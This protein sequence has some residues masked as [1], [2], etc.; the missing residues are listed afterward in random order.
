MNFIAGKIEDYIG[1]LYGGLGL[2]IVAINDV[3]SLPK[4]FIKQ[5]E[6]INLEPE[7]QAPVSIQEKPVKA[8]KRINKLFY[9]WKKDRIVLFSREKNTPQVVLTRKET[10]LFDFL[11]TDRRTI[12][13]IAGQIWKVYKKA[14][15][16]KKVNNIRE[17][18][19]RINKR[20]EK[21]VPE[22]I[23]SELDNDSYYLTV[24]VEED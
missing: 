21:F 5:F 1:G 23:I 13:E 16:E 12:E 4:Y 22:D 3:A 7:K 2:L 8:V 20:C 18:R 10:E 24:E 19:G 11:R 15:I 9:T 14:D 17:L 6:M